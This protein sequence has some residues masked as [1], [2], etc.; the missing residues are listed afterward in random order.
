MEYTKTC[1]T[2][3]YAGFSHCDECFDGCCDD[4]YCTMPKESGIIGG[5]DCVCELYKPSDE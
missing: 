3:H 4:V 1:A 2:C 5:W